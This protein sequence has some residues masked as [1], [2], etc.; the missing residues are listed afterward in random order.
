[1]TKFYANSEKKGNVIMKANS[2]MGTSKRIQNS[3]YAVA[4][5]GGF[6]GFHGNPLLKFI[7]SN[8]VVRQIE[9]LL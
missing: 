3:S 6:Q 2:M 1:M 7:Y 8:R 5:P 4:D 9:T